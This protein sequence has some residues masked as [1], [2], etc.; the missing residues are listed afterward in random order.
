MAASGNNE[1]KDAEPVN[2]SS[3]AAQSEPLAAQPIGVGTILA[4]SLAVDAIE[5]PGIATESI[6]APPLEAPS[7]NAPRAEV[8]PM[9]VAECVVEPV[10]STEI[11]AAHRPEVSRWRRPLRKNERVGSV[12]GLPILLGRLRSLWWWWAVMLVVSA[13]DG[14]HEPRQAPYL[15]G[16]LTLNERVGVWCAG[17][18]A[19]NRP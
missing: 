12:F 6:H 2:G 15:V 14:W 5:V 11:Q 1:P 13:S 16:Q 8:D 10:C 3:G 4:Q 7:A 19:D 17:N 18:P 9:E